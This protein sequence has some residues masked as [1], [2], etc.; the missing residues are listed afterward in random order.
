MLAV[1]CWAVFVK[2]VARVLSLQTCV[3]KAHMLGRKIFGVSD[4]G[5][6]DANTLQSPNC[7]LRILR[8]V[9]IEVGEELP[10]VGWE[11]VLDDRL[12]DFSHKVELVVDVMNAQKMRGN[13]FLGSVVVNEGLGDSHAT[14]RTWL[15]AHASAAFFQGTEVA[16]ESCISDVEDTMLGDGVVE[17]CSPGR[18]DTIEHVCAKGYAD[19]QILGIPNSHDVS[20]LQVGQHLGTGLDHAAVVRLR[21]SATEPTDRDAGGISR[22]HS[23][24]ALSSH[25]KVKTTLDNAKQVLGLWILVRSNASVEPSNTALHRFAHAGFVWA[26]GDENIIELHHNIASDGVLQ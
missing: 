14:L 7:P 4:V 20:R 17:A 11:P 26:G 16:R 10:D 1:S 25:L 8:S 19:D 13:G 21:F 15:A 12:P 24:A 3:S 18:P 5:Q 23:F 2:S 9:G 22:Q 6:I